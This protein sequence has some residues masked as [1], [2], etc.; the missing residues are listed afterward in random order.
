MVT[1]K[2]LKNLKEEYSQFYKKLTGVGKG[3]EEACMEEEP[4]F[5]PPKIFD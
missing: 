2:P 1:I 5:E 4:A 3:I